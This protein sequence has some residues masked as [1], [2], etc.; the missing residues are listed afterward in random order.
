MKK[1]NIDIVYI[2][3]PNAHH[4]RLVKLMLEN[5]KHVLCEKPLSPSCKET[6][7][8]IEL[9]KSKKLF[10]MEG[11]WSRFFPVY[12]ALDKHVQTNGLGDIFVVNVQFGVQISDDE[13]LLLVFLY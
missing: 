12:E 11:L 6:K 7:E 1:S 4:Y 10:L 3:A 2:G 5:D 8:L 13:R 9:A